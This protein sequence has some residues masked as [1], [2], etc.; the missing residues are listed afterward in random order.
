MEEQWKDIDGFEG[1][2]VSSFGIV[3]VKASGM[4]VEPFR[5]SGKGN[6]LYVYLRRR[7]EHKAQSV[8][9]LVAYAFVPNPSGAKTLRF[10]DGDCAE[11]RAEEEHRRHFNRVQA[12]PEGEAVRPYRPQHIERYVVS[13]KLDWTPV[14][15]S[16]HKPVKSS[17]VPRWSAQTLCR[18]EGSAV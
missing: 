3:R 10:I 12:P 1:Y 15:L 2:E 16:G 18:L 7:G 14:L 4:V 6:N 13:H 9:R 8:P 11:V 5:A 17:E